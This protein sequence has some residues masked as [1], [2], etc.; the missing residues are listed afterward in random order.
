M[1]VPRQLIK[2]IDTDIDIIAT[3]LL[4][5]PKFHMTIGGAVYAEFRDYYKKQ[6]QKYL[7]KFETL[8]ETID[9]EL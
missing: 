1:E 3:Y 7:P 8:M 4:K 2:Y 5:M 6:T 9:P